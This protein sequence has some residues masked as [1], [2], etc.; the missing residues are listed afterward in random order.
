VTRAD[1]W[2]GVGELLIDG[3][4]LLHRLAGSADSGALRLLLANLQA[5]LPRGLPATVVLDGVPDPGAPMRVRVTPHL[6][7]RHAGRISADQALLDAIERVS[8]SQ[9]SGTVIVTDDTEL[10]QRIR[11]AGGRA[12]PLDWYLA[13]VAGGS[14]ATPPARTGLGAGRPRSTGPGGP[15]TAAGAAGSNH[16]DGREPWKP[17]RGA[18]RKRGNPRRRRS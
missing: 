5:G 14:A 9:R 3:N 10:R 16:E 2:R 12:E 11:E 7:V 15:T 6:T 18:T 8:F 13:R 4:N 17:G 1:P